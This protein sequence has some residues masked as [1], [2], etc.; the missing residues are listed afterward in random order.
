M[1]AVNPDWMY[2][3]GAYNVGG[4]SEQAG[5]NFDATQLAQQAELARK[6]TALGFLEYLQETQ[7][8][9]FS[10]VT[11]LQ[12]YNTFGGGTLAPAAALAGS[13]GVGTPAP[14]PYGEMAQRL[15]EGLGEFTGGTPYNPNTGKPMT[16]QEMAFLRMIDMGNPNA[17]NMLGQ[18][19]TGSQGSGPISGAGSGGNLGGGVRPRPTGPSG[20]GPIL[21]PIEMDQKRLADA[22]EAIA[23][24]YSGTYGQ[25]GS[26]LSDIAQESRRVSLLSPN[27]KKTADRY[28]KTRSASK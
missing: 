21:Q 17:L 6:Q 18:S 12:Q 23:A 16:P 1:P 19:D 15:M 14:S 2:G 13:G 27:Y 4:G 25:P 20:S 22:A 8:D 26:Q 5:F 11:A 9:P 3:G 28:L 24:K 10:I 7:R